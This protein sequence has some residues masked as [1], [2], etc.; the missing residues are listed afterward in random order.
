[1]SIK[2]AV[3]DIAGTTLKDEHNVTKVFKGAL[4]KFG[5]DIPAESIDP[6]MGYEKKWAITKIVEL[7]TGKTPEEKIIASIYQEFIGDMISFYEEAPL[8]VLP[9]VEET[10][11][12][13]QKSGIKI[14]INTGF[15]REIAQI[16][17]DRLEWEKNNVIDIMIASDEVPLGRPEPYMIQ[18]L[19]KKLN[20]TDP[21]QVAKIG[22]TEVDIREGQNAGCAYVIGVTTGIFSRE[23]LEPYEPTH[24]VDD[25]ADIIPILTT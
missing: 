5:Y 1:M 25:M 15:S 24:I 13:L 16:V 8:E 18:T 3:F 17:M 11:A 12:A 21:L 10:F 6:L 20:I 23:E 2:L 19:M 9:H 4:S 14:A 7:Y 22:D